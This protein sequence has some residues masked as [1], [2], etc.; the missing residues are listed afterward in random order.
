M[1]YQ[2][3]AKVAVTLKAVYSSPNFLPDKEAVQVWYELL[4]D[5]PYSVA[6]EAVR[7]YVMT[8]KFPPT[9]AGIR[10]RVADMVEDRALS[11]LEAWTKA[12]RAIMRGIYHSE[13]EFAKLPPAVQ[14][15]VG[16]PKSLE[17]WAKM[18]SNAIESTVQ[19][20]FYR[21]YRSVLKRRKRDIQTA[22]AKAITA[23]GA[24][25]IGEDK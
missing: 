11:E 3:F 6:S 2:E 25:M 21:A 7:R 19:A 15:A 17:D 4:K 20:N 13:E 10:E 8:E 24:A 23:A 9:P 18:D 5:L 12:Y 22:N 16:S 14:D 1:T